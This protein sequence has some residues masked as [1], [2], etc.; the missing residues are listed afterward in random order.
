MTAKP[1]GRWGGSGLSPAQKLGKAATNN[2]PWR[3]RD[4]AMCQALWNAL[5]AQAKRVSRNPV[6]RG[7]VNGIRKMVRSVLWDL[8]AKPFDRLSEKQ[9][10]V[11]ERG[12]VFHGLAIPARPSGDE[13]PSFDGGPKPLKPPTRVV[14]DEDS[15]D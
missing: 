11:I 6:W 12:L 13:P 3:D 10:E 2:D 1:A 8:Q 5:E 7:H 9:R 15:E 14:H 4:L